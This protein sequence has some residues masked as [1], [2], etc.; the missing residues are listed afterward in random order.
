[1]ITDIQWE[2][3]SS[4]RDIL[5]CFAHATKVF[6]YVYEPNV[7]H[8][9][10]ECVN[11]VTTLREYENNDYFSAIIF[12]MKV[13]C[14]EYFTNFSYIYG[15][16]CLLDPGVRKEGLE[17]MLEHYYEVLGVSYNHAIYVQYCLDLLYRLVD[18]YA[19]KNQ[20]VMPPKTNIVSRFNSTISSILTK[21]TKM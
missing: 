3:A 20:N 4:I 19:P 6:S 10:I 21:K 1:M 9:I 16:A 12:D 2:L 13:K 7:H 5:D 18:M 8:V 14:I 11:N 15:I 17:N